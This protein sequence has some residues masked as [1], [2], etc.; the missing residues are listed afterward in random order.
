MIVL[1]LGRVGQGLSMLAEEANVP[2]VGVSRGAD[3]EALGG[4]PSRGPILVCVNADDLM[5]C[6]ESVPKNRQRD[7]VFVQNGMLDSFLGASGLDENTRGLLYFAVP[8]RG[9]RPAPGGA[10]VF[11]GPH[12]NAVVAWFKGV[13]L[14][15]K[16][17]GRAAFT[18]EMASKLIWNCTFGLM[19]EVYGASVGELVSQKR[20]AIDGLVD[21][22]VA[23]ANAALGS[24]LNAMIV[25]RGACEYSLSIPNYTG[26][27]KQHPWRNGWFVDS[28][29][30]LGIGTPLHQQLMQRAA[31]NKSNSPQ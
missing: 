20:P 11:S 12:A 4:N 21:E 14:E 17:V 15:A 30:R 10:S 26:A 28:A 23:V 18:E 29:S 27:L 24:K 6:I 13:G 9:D 25:S 1:G 2:F 16:A 8:K 7:L 22:F 19:C 5:G 31:E 3:H